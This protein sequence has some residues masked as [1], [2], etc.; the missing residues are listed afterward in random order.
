MNSEFH[1]HYNNI[2]LKFQ[3]LK[4]NRRQFVKKRTLQDWETLEFMS[5]SSKKCKSLDGKEIRTP[6]LN[7][8]LKQLRIRLDS[9]LVDIKSTADPEQVTP[10]TI[11]SLCLQPITNEEKNY[12]ISEVCKEI[13]ENGIHVYGDPNC[14]CQSVSLHSA[15]IFSQLVDADIGN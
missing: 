7:L 11:A 10:R 2:R 9:L 6:I 8:Q 12:K 1:K 4:D 15:Y 5:Q 13:V 3:K 14:I